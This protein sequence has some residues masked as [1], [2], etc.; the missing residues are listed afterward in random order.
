MKV[1]NTN[2]FNDVSSNLEII[3]PTLLFFFVW[4]SIAL[5][6]VSETHRRDVELS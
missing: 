3:L 6:S 5:K 2:Y 1:R 4:N